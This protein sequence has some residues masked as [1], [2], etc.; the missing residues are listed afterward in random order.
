MGKSDGYDRW[1]S[2]K[3]MT[4]GS[5]EFKTLRPA[6]LRSVGDRTGSELTVSGGGALSWG[7]RG[8]GGPGRGAGLSEHGRLS[9]SRARRAPFPCG[10]FAPM[11]Q[12]VFDSDLHS[13][14]QLD[15]P[16]TN[17]PP[18]RWLHKAKEPSGL[19]PHPC[20]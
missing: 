8:R 12:F 9:S 10:R 6:F 2:K 19:P 5:G 7:A 4:A 17:A 15:T 11:A 18:S 1:V 14:L 16:I 13:L 20:R 3:P